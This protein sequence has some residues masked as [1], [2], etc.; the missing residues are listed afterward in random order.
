MRQGAGFPDKRGTWHHRLVTP[1]SPE[2][3]ARQRV[4]KHTDC[5]EYPVTGK[6]MGEEGFPEGKLNFIVLI[7]T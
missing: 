3:R 7:Y 1:D 2:H 4:G 5:S 6:K